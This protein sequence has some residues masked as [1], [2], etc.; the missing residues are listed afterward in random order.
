MQIP[1]LK[2]SFHWC[3]EIGVLSEWDT[4]SI[5]KTWLV[6][7]YKRLSQMTNEHKQKCGSHTHSQH[8]LNEPC[9]GLIS[10][11][12]IKWDD[13]VK[14]IF[15]YI[16]LSQFCGKTIVCQRTTHFNE[17]V[18]D[19]VNKLK[20]IYWRVKHL[21]VQCD[22]GVVLILTITNGSSEISLTIWGHSGHHNISPKY[23]C[24]NIFCQQRYSVPNT[25]WQVSLFWLML[26]NENRMWYE[27]S[28]SI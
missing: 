6:A 7:R 12:G 4:A 16:I 19:N 20:I 3:W 14:I 24:I 2:M 27:N 10:I 22:Q 15:F 18:W 11:T 28:Q 13:K 25:T 1:T 9:Q 21:I 26:P 17:G 5:L 8:R 23:R